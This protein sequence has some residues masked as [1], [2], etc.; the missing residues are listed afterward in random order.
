MH[1]LPQ[2]HAMRV[3]RKRVNKNDIAETHFVRDFTPR[4]REAHR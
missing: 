1:L 2:H 3:V 4:T